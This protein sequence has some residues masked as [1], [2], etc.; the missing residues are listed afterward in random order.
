MFTVKYVQWLMS[1]VVCIFGP[2]AA[3][4][5]VGLCSSTAGFFKPG[6]MFEHVYFEMS[7]SSSVFDPDV[8]KYTLYLSKQSQLTNKYPN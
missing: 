5:L 2:R 6:P 3:V 7:M 8:Q 4:F 1:L